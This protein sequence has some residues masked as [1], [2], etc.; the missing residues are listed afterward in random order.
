MPPPC[1]HY[2]CGQ[3]AP[4]Y[5]TTLVRSKSKHVVVLEKLELTVKLTIFS[6][7]E[8]K[9]NCPICKEMM[10]SSN[11]VLLLCGL[12]VALFPLASA[13]A[14][15]CSQDFKNCVGYACGTTKASRPVR[16]LCVALQWTSHRLRGTLGGLHQQ[17][18]RMLSRPGLSGRHDLPAMR[19]VGPCSCRRPR[20]H[21]Y[22]SCCRDSC[23]SCPYPSCCSYHIS[24][25]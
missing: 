8:A 4:G 16:D 12:A 19:R 18:E 21:Y 14:G 10:L 7:N 13:A 15:C 23:C 6:S 3:G 17:C 20:P 24:S 2:D 9:N 22:Q 5:G 25:D 11:L 1:D